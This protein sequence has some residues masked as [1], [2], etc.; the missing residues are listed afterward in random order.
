MR[1]VIIEYFYTLF[2]THFY[3]N[4]INIIISLYGAMVHTS[5]PPVNEPGTML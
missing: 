3:C 5:A 1:V 2:I 4:T